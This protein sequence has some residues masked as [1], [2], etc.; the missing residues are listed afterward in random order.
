MLIKNRVVSLQRL[1]N[2]GIINQIDDYCYYMEL[3][4]LILQ[5][6][7]MGEGI[8]QL[9]KVDKVYLD[10]TNLVFALAEQQQEIGNIRETVFFNQMRVR[11]H[12]MNN[13]IVQ[14]SGSLGSIKVQLNIN[15]K[16]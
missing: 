14:I 3:A 7:N 10:N 16:K 5:L 12:L 9:G 8:G 15:T 1:L 11:N 2:Y 6:R 13:S 4:G